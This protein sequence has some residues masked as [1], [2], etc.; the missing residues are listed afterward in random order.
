M[1]YKELLC[2]GGPKDGKMMPI[3]H[4]V[5]VISVPVLSEPDC[6]ALTDLV[7]PP[8]PDAT[9]DVMEYRREWLRDFDGT[10]VEVL[11]ASGVNNPI[12]R[13]I[14]GYKPTTDSSGKG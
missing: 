12:Q 10:I 3:R 14:T 4:G 7:T 2:I 8:R 1:S 6:V 9:I 5:A 11:V 13:L